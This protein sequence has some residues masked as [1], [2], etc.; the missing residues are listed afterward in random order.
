MPGIADGTIAVRLQH[1]VRHFTGETGEPKIDNS[2]ARENRLR[3]WA[4]RLGYQLRKDRSRS[5]GLEHRGAYLV[6]SLNTDIP[7]IGCNFDA[8]L[9]EVELFL[10]AE[11]QRLRAM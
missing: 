7:S 3:R 9:D 6:V 8:D 4:G 10:D 11:E 1:H 5:W 2:K